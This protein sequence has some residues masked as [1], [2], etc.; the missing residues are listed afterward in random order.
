MQGFFMGGTG[1][2]PV[3]PSFE[4]APAFAGFRGGLLVFCSVQEFHSH[5]P[6]VFARVCALPSML[7]V[8]RGS[9]VW[10]RAIVDTAV[11]LE[12]IR[13]GRRCCAAVVS[14]AS[15]GCYAQS[16]R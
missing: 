16:R 4:T 15:N 9:T 3:T 11:L 5:T 10:P 13:R 8:A 2:E 6:A 12:R 14:L 1:L 7:V